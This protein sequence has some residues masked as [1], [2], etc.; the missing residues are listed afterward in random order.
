[1]NEPAITTP[2]STIIPPELGVDVQPNTD[3]HTPAEVELQRQLDVV[4]GQIDQLKETN[5]QLFRLAMGSKSDDTKTPIQK[6]LERFFASHFN[7]AELS[8]GE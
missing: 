2:D 4:R 8:K 6:K 5:A 7:V 3:V 1:M